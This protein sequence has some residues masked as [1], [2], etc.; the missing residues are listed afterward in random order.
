MLQH[1][2]LFKVR[3]ECYMTLSLSEHA[4]GCKISLIWA[5]KL[6]LLVVSQKDEHFSPSFYFIKVPSVRPLH[7][8]KLL[9][10][11]SKNI[12]P[13]AYLFFVLLY[14]EVIYWLLISLLNVAYCIVS[15]LSPGLNLIEYIFSGK[16]KTSNTGW[17]CRE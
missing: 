15:D 8:V 9:D 2:D 5:S 7:S 16:F 6:C 10:N 4:N 13:L 14:Q 3:F 12:S 11:L 17:N 1:F